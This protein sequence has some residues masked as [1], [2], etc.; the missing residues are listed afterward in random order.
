MSFNTSRHI[1]QPHPTPVLSRMEVVKVLRD[2]GYKINGVELWQLVCQNPA[3]ADFRTSGGYHYWLATEA[4][5]IELATRIEAGRL[6]KG[7]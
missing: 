5:L 2:L 3:L 4:N 6:N 7:A 1:N